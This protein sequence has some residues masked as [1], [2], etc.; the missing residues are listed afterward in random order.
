MS[1]TDKG[2]LMFSEWLEAMSQLNPKAYKEMMNAIYLYQIKGIEPPE[3][4]GKAQMV[5][6]IVSAKD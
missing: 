4:K 1:Q 6:A 5:A 2:V 3:F